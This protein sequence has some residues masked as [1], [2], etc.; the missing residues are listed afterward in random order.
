MWR[1]FIPFR[2]FKTGFKDALA[3]ALEFAQLWFGNC[4]K[5]SLLLNLYDFLLMRILVTFHQSLP[6][7][8][9]CRFFFKVVNQPI[10]MGFAFLTAVGGEIKFRHGLTSH[11][12]VRILTER[13]D[14]Q[15]LSCFNV[16][17]NQV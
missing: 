14:Y 2:K 3:E 7:R 17:V 13:M 11:L 15:R 6:K 12:R 4:R 5:S 10:Y 1:R 8:D 9:P 16:A